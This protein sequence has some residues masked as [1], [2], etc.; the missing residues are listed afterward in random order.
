VDQVRLNPVNYLAVA[1]FGQQ[2]A[3]HWGV[4]LEASGANW[5]LSVA[6]EPGR[7][8]SRIQHKGLAALR[9]PSADGALSTGVRPMQTLFYDLRYAFRKLRQSPGFALTAIVTLAL[10][11]GANVIVF[12]VLNSLL[13]KP[14]NFSHPWRVVF[15]ERTS[16]D[17]GVSSYPDYLDLRD[18]NSTFSSLALFRMEQV[19]I[20]GATGPAQPVWGYQ[21]SGNYFGTLGVRPLLGRMLQPSDDMHPGAGSYVVLSYDAWHSMFAG[22]PGIVGKTVHLN[23]SPYLVVGV[24]PQKFAGTEHW[25]APQFWVPVANQ[26]QLDGYD[27]LHARSDQNIWLIGRLKP[28]V[29]HA[30]AAANVAAMSHELAKEYPQQDATLA[31]KLTQP[32]LMGDILGG[33]VRAFLWGVMLLAGM[34]LLA[35]CAN[36]GSLV[37]ARA[38]DRSRELAVRVAIGAGRGRIL[39]QLL[40]E[41]VMLSIAGGAAG[42]LLALSLLDALNRWNPVSDFGGHIEI[43][44]DGWVYGFAI[45]ASLAAG[46]LFG[47][48]PARQIWK[49]DPS[50]AMKGGAN[51]AP[52]K[53]GWPVSDV[54]LT[55]QVAICCL[56]VT[57]SL[58]AVRGLSRTLHANLGFAPKGVTLAR[59][60]LG[61]DGYTID[62]AAPVQRKLLD[63]VAHLPGVTSAAYANTTPLSTNESFTGVY[64]FDT[65]D[66]ST[67]NQKFDTN[68]YSISPGYFATAGTRLLAGREFTWQDDAKSPRVAIVNQTFARKLFGTDNAVG[69]YFRAGGK[70]PVQIVGIVEDGKYVTMTEDP[71]AALFYSILQNPFSETVLLVRSK[72]QD[73]AMAA[74]VRGA[75]R[76][77]ERTLP[78]SGLGSWQEDL[79]TALLPTYAATSALGVFGGLAILLSLTG[80][81]GLASYT[82]SRRMRELGIRVALG[83]SHLQVV[84]AALR[85]PIGLLAFGSG[86][87]LIAGVAASR[88]L[89]S[90][91]YK[92]TPNDPLVLAGVVLTMLLVGAL[93]TWIPARRVLAV[94]PVQV[95]RQE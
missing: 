34:V 33:P 6:C 37:G 95:L 92:A 74:E 77:V 12:S 26:A 17:Y 4:P 15:L 23:K 58:V 31:Y 66:F 73:A 27:W 85:R 49:T 71:R 14:L 47:S 42:L 30:A 18:R 13:L 54:L 50:Q 59:L 76:Q 82:V 68:Y 35:A 75:I 25:F 3:L 63:A 16:N 19:G 52:G 64:S 81:F 39:R 84:G 7:M 60:D 21:V 8:L 28:G 38:A 2:N 93:A 36:L 72:R 89:A 56:L 88:L 29:T 65:T 20:V 94:D 5:P 79:S 11:I 22:D 78:I 57:A 90:I 32:G 80:I 44:P 86:A 41:S 67:R 10:G 51:L 87:G 1:A 55:G 46:V 83:A 61:L 62:T 40:T 91:V 43:H 45:L 70:R 53:R 48:V 9:S 69:K 24:A